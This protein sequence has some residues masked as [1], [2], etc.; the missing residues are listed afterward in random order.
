VALTAYITQVRRLLHDPSGQYWSDS[1]LTDYINEARNRICK[2]TRCLRTYIP[3]LVT[4]TQG[5]EQY[6][7]SDLQSAAGFT[8]NYTGY[9]IIDVMGVTVIWGQTR[10]KLG[11]APWT[12]FDAMM[13]YWTNMQSRPVLFSRLGALSVYIGPQPDQS[14]VSDWDLALIPPPL[15]S[16]STPEAIPE[17]FVTPIKYYAAYVAKF[18]EQ[19]IAEAQ[20]F[21]KMYKRQSLIEASAFM[22][23]V[24]PDPYA[25]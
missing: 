7:L 6:L 11:Y 20:M 14:Y 18:R 8:T 1:E 17:P 10:I 19:A 15:V 12:R 25:K 22:G 24:I 16:D 4:M 9:T 21:E 13:R 3:G 23:R 2:D 5:D